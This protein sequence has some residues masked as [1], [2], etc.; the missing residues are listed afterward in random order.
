MLLIISIV[1]FCQQ[2]NSSSAF[3]TENYLKKSK[4]QMTAATILVSGGG[5]LATIGIIE[6]SNGFSRAFD[7]SN[8]NSGASEMNTGNALAITGG[9]QALS[10]IPFFIASHRSKKKSMSLSFKNETIPLPKNNSFVSRPVPSLS[11]KINL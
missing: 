8:P 10:S 6:W 2:M 5:L 4:S 9:A 1:S 7:F 3:N 11:L